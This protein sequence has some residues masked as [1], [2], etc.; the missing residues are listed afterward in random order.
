MKEQYGKDSKWG[1]ISKPTYYTKGVECI[2]VMIQQFG[3]EQVKS[4]CIIN[5][6]KYIFR[7]TN[8]HD[9]AVD[10]VKKAMWYLNKYLEL[11]SETSC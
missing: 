1:D 6:F 2:D 9:S 8:K 11:C 5:A 7:C 3:V 10:D 4:Y